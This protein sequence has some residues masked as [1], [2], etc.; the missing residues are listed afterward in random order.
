MIVRPRSRELILSTAE[1]PNR[2]FYEAVALPSTPQRP[3]L[4][5]EAPVVLGLTGIKI[6]QPDRSPAFECAESL[7][8]SPRWEPNPNSYARR[9]NP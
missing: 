8:G 3:F 2:C 6:V 1:F 7:V 4:L 9:I 5:L